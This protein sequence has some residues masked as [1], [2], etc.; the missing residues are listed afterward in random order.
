MKHIKI[1]LGLLIIA[2][3]LFGLGAIFYGLHSIYPPIA[4]IVIGIVSVLLSAVINQIIPN[5]G[6]DKY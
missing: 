2:L 4:Y 3:L 1:I 5:K 6:G